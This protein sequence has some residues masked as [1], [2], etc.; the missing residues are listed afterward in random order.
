MPDLTLLCSRQNHLC[1][2]VLPSLLRCVWFS[3]LSEA[4]LNKHKPPL[5][6]T[7]LYLLHLDL[8]ILQEC[9]CVRTNPG[10]REG[11]FPCYPVFPLDSPLLFP[12]LPHSFVSPPC[13]PPTPFPPFLLSLLDFC[14]SHSEILYRKPQPGSD[15]CERSISKAMKGLSAETKPNFGNYWW[16]S[17]L[18]FLAISQNESYFTGKCNFCLCV[19]ICVCSLSVNVCVSHRIQGNVLKGGTLALTHFKNSTKTLSHW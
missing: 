19:H 3:P 6:L 10:E 1:V 12:F 11:I 14:F 7:T 5:L 15:N 9:K 13:N 16:G 4:V 8:L 2:L 18:G 17:F